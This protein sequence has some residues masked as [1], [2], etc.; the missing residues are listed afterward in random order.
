MEVTADALTDD[1]V[2]TTFESVLA[3]ELNV[4][5]SELDI[6]YDRESGVLTYAIRSDDI[7]TIDDAIA[8]ITQDDFATELELSDDIVIDSIIPPTDVV[9]TIDVTVDASEVEDVSSTVSDVMD[10]I[11]RQDSS[12]EVIGEGNDYHIYHSHNFLF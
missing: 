12:F 1:E 11:Q 9:A 6:S 10:A 5:P 7:D 3:D 2:M 4:H 8:R